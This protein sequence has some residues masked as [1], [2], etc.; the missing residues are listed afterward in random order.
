MAKR[1]FL[2]ELNPLGGSSF[3]WVGGRPW[4]VCWCCLRPATE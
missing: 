1:H 3:T 4:V 2:K